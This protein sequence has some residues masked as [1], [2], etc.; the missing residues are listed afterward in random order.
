MR[1][2]KAEGDQELVDKLESEIISEN[3]M[4]EADE[5]PTSIKEFLENTPFK[6]TDTPGKEDVVLTRNFGDEKYVLPAAYIC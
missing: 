2:L 6:I 5:L 1:C 3:E 4:K